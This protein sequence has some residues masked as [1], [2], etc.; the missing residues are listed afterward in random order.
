VPSIT[1]NG[2]TFLSA[3]DIQDGLSQTIAFGEV[4]PDMVYTVAETD[5]LDTLKSHCQ[6]VQQIPA[7]EAGA[8][9]WDWVN[10]LQDFTH[11]MTPNTTSCQNGDRY[12]WGGAVTASSMHAGS[13]N[14]LAADGSAK[15]L[16]ENVDLGAWRALGT[17]QSGDDVGPW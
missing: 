17:R 11:V 7:N 10:T 1:A 9:S 13:I 6:S 12:P 2:L 16:S 8:N 15:P 5:S 4:L 14:V 3:A